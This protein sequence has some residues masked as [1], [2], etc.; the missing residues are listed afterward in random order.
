[1]PIRSDSSAR[2]RPTPINSS[3]PTDIP[4][5]EVHHNRAPSNAGRRHRSPSFSRGS[6]ND[7]RRSEGDIRGYTPT[8][9]QPPAPVT[10]GVPPVE[11]A[12]DEN[13]TRRYFE[14]NARERAERARRQV[15]ED[16]RS[17][18]ESP[19]RYDRSGPPLRRDDYLNEEDYNAPVDGKE[20]ATITD[21]PMGDPSIGNEIPVKKS[22]EF[23]A[24]G[25]RKRRN[26]R[27]VLESLP[28]LDGWR[29]MR[30]KESGHAC[31]LEGPRDIFDTR[32]FFFSP[33]PYHVAEHC[34]TMDY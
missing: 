28:N 26:R 34:D 22:K 15:E 23:K 5:A 4:K 25:R 18:G 3:R 33:P 29:R 16:P 14:K 1:M 9:Y 7:F 8:S 17:Y 12:M 21:K 2:S 32:V 11:P 27:G 6:T 19:R 24:H 20:V 13:D 31:L 30:Q 10:V